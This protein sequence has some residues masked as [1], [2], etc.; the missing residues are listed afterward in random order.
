MINIGKKTWTVIGLTLLM[1]SIGCKATSMPKLPRLGWLGPRDA[2]TVVAAETK[3]ATELPPPSS[4]AV[5]KS[6]VRQATASQTPVRSEP[7]ANA[8]VNTEPLTT[9]PATPYPNFQVAQTNSP[10]PPNYT[11]GP[12]GTAAAQP[13]GNMPIPQ[14]TAVKAGKAKA[15]SAPPPL[16]PSLDQYFIP[17]SRP[18]GAGEKLVVELDANRHRIARVRYVRFL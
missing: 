15:D 14:A 9:Y 2:E 12:Y 6:P 8:A 11:A 3:P 17:D 1:S 4:A 13:G 7:M 18:S 5:P 16:P 10:A